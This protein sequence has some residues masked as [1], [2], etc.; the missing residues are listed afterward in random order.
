MKRPLM[1]TASI[2]AV[3]AHSIFTI[4]YGIVFFVIGSLIS[5]LSDNNS[6]S[7]QGL[8][9]L[10]LLLIF[11]VVAIVLNSINISLWNK[12]FETYRK[13]IFLPIINVIMNFIIISLLIFSLI[14]NAS[15][16]ILLILYLII[17]FIIN[18][19]YIVDMLLENKRKKLQ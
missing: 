9:L 15:N 16:V 7:K 1:L 8:I 12:N 10:S 13:R 3:V 14:N 17:L 19:L 4:L 18:I 5:G 2:T 11:M 6:N